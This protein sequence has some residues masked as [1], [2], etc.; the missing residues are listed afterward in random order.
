MI[1]ELY[2]ASILRLA[3]NMPRAGRLAAPDASAEKVALLCGSRI[4]FNRSATQNPFTATQM[5]RL[6]LPSGRRARMAPPQ[7]TPSGKASKKAG[8]LRSS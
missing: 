1:D 2:S 5:W 8:Q 4:G 3:A 6:L 7:A